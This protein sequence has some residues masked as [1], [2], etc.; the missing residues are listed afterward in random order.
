M[1]ENL[2]G[3]KMIKFCRVLLH[4]STWNL[5]AIMFIELTQGGNEDESIMLDVWRWDWLGFNT[6]HGCMGL[7][8]Y[9]IKTDVKPRIY[10]ER[11]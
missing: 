5:L 7:Y 8:C 6:L 4:S 9:L 11:E 10:I 1:E 2:A 3:I